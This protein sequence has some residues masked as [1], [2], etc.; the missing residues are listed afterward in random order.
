MPPQRALTRRS[1]LGW[2][3]L[4]AA[5]G[6]LSGCSLFRRQPAPQATAAPP[7]AM[8]AATSARPKIVFAR[9]SGREFDVLGS[10]VARFNASGLAPSVEVEDLAIPGDPFQ[11]LQVMAAGDIAPDVH[12][13]ADELIPE[14]SRAGILLSLDPF[15]A[16]D[17]AFDLGDFYEQFLANDRYAGQLWALPWTCAASYLYINLDLFWAAGVAPPTP[18]WSWDDFRLSALAL[19]CEDPVRWGCGPVQGWWQMA[20]RVWQAGAEAFNPERN[21]CLLDQPEAVAALEF[22]ADLVI[23]DKALPGPAEARGGG[24]AL[25]RD[26]KA[27]MYEDYLYVIQGWKQA[28]FKWQIAYQ[29][30]RSRKVNALMSGSQG[31]NARTSRPDDAW[32]LLKYMTGPEALAAWSTAMRLPCARKSANASRPYVDPAIDINWELVDVGIEYGRLPEVVPHNAEVVRMLERMLSTIFAGEK[33]VRE[34]LD[35]TVPAVNTIVE[36]GF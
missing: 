21:R 5:A 1:L 24:M 2:S 23:G 26:G 12:L 15:L 27:A 20:E 17:A 31:I 25:F 34:A 19:T 14:W 7:T 16:S 22:W 28:P 3:A 10:L 8:P 30:Y 9:P 18:D 33:T 36:Q 13:V 35:E 4:S 29:P 6:V 11:S 32:A